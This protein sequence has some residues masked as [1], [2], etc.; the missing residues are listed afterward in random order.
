MC[1]TLVE[2]RFP[3]RASFA[4]SLA[5]VGLVLVQALYVLN[6]ISIVVPKHHAHNKQQPIRV[7]VVSNTSNTNGV[8][9]TN[10]TN[11]QNDTSKATKN[12]SITEKITKFNRVF[13]RLATSMVEGKTEKVLKNQNME[14]ESEGYSAFVIEQLSADSIVSKNDSVKLMNSSSINNNNNNYH[15]WSSTTDQKH[16][17]QVLNNTGL[18][19]VDNFQYRS[20]RYMFHSVPIHAKKSE[21]VTSNAVNDRV[22]I[23]NVPHYPYFTHDEHDTINDDV[24]LDG[25]DNDDYNTYEFP[26]KKF[27]VC[28]FVEE[29]YVY[30]LPH[31]MQQLYRCWSWWKSHGYD[32]TTPV[33]V[34]PHAKLPRNNFVNGF[35]SALQH[36][37]GLRVLM[38]NEINEIGLSYGKNDD[39]NNTLIIDSAVSTVIS[40]VTPKYPPNLVDP[41]NV[42]G[43]E[44]PTCTYFSFHKIEDAIELRS[45]ILEYLENSIL[46]NRSAV[47]EKFILSMSSDSSNTRNQPELKPVTKM[48]HNTPRIAILNRHNHRELLVAPEIAAILEESGG[49]VETVPIVYFDNN[50]TFAEQ[51][52]F[53]ATTDIIISPHG[54][55]LTGIP[56]M[57]RCGIIYEIFPTGYYLPYYFGSLASAS[58]LQHGYTITTNTSN[59]VDWKVECTESMQ[60]RKS[61]QSVRNK[62]I[63]VDP[64]SIAKSVLTLVDSWKQCQHNQKKNL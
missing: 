48:R 27:A 10:T 31:T 24:N 49:S 63:C 45:N 1:W 57:P 30:H 37:I 16:Q 53:F 8:V 21:S 43:M 29:Q 23:S 7:V 11:S 51:I 60:D 47:N 25:C 3:S 33:L 4:C 61:R 56:F 28:A 42:F 50:T 55:Q 17:C 59:S 58:G 36:I 2:I 20:F 32:T 52:T 13:R 46:D 62:P 14:G 18:S 26:M 15:M 6:N 12:D 41:R 44:D 9:A 5:I 35:V 39:N 64:Q 40:Y 22:T 38:P 34:F 54:A 19:S